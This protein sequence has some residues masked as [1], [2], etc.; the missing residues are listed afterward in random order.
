M[1]SYALAI[2]PDSPPGLSKEK[3]ANA[4]GQ[5]KKTMVF[6]S[7][8]HFVHFIHDRILSRLES[9]NV[10]PPGLVRLVSEFMLIFG[11]MESTEN[12]EKSKVEVSGEVIPSEE[13]NETIRQ[14][15]ESLNGTEGK[16][17]LKLKVKKQNDTL[18]IER[19]ETYGELTIDQQNLWNYLVELVEILV[20]EADGDDVELEIEIEH[21]LEIEEEIEEPEIEE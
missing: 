4:P 16:H 19:N 21:E 13:V 14:L 17:E 5:L 12:E 2:K 18:S 15:V 6:E 1:S 10:S 3:N 11:I 7:Q 8:K 9:K 20:G